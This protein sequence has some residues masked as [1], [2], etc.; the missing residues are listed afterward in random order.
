M[1]NNIPRVSLEDTLQLIQMM[2]NAAVSK[3]QN[4]QA[5]RLEPVVDEMQNLVASSP[6]YQAPAAPSSGV[7][8]QSDF[9][10][11]LEV[12]MARPEEKPVEQVSSS[13]MADRNQMVLAMHR[14]GMPDVDI[15]RQFGTS[16]EEVRLVINLSEKGKLR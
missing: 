10:A 16:R 9:R 13:T 4:E 15:A 6:G 5:Q 12:S 2:R 11:L 8:G 14:A 7:M 1:A 3:G